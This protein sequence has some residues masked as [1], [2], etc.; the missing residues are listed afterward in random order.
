[1]EMIGRNSVFE[2]HHLVVHVV[3]LVFIGESHL[4]RQDSHVNIVTSK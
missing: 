1:M 2:S 4:T 3:I